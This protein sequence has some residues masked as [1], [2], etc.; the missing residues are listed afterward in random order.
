[1]ASNGACDD[2]GGANGNG[3]SGGGAM[4]MDVAGDGKGGGTGGERKVRKAC[5]ALY[6]VVFVGVFRVVSVAA[7]VVVPVELVSL[8]WVFALV[9]SPMIGARTTSKHA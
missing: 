2:Q 4:D 9:A 1:M 7:S 3:E 8:S 5:A 6:C